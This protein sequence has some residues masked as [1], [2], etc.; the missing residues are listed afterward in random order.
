MIIENIEND[1]NLD[2]GNIMELIGSQLISIDDNKIV[3]Q[4]DNQLYTITICK[5]Y[6]DCCG[7]NVVKTTLL[8]D[9]EDTKNNP[10]ITN[11]E[12]GGDVSI[13]GDVIYGD[14]TKITFFGLDKDL[15]TLEAASYSGSGWEYGACVTLICK[16]LKINE[17]ISQ[18]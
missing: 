11:I 2:L 10:I 4:K 5:D 15:A 8:V 6:G 17:T 16:E 7:Y 14:C 1:F 12:C 3:V 9:L 13:E 18:W